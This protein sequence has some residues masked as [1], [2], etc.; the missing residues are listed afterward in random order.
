MKNITL[1]AL[2]AFSLL[3]TSIAQPISEQQH[4]PF[5]KISTFTPYQQSLP[6]IFL[7]MVDDDIQKV[8]FNPAR[9]GE[10]DGGFISTN[11]IPSGN[12]DNFSLIGLTK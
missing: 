4:L 5:Q 3:G 10:M 12:Q 6:T 11:I 2:F 9:A 8:I 7:F 1:L